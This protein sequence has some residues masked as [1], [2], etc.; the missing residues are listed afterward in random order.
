MTT[1]RSRPW[2]RWDD[3]G[4]TARIDAYWTSN[5][6]ES[7]HRRALAAFVS[8]HARGGP[9]LEVGSGTGLV[10]E[11]LV[12]EVLANDG[13]LGMDVSAQ[14]VDIARRRFPSGRF[15][16][17]DAYRM[18]FQDGAFD[19]AVAFEVFCHLPAL[20]A[21]LK[22]MFRVSRRKVL[23]TTWDA[24]PDAS[25]REVTDEG[26]IYWRY[27]PED[28][29]AAV[30]EVAPDSLAAGGERMYPSIMAWSVDVRPGSGER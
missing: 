18:P 22:E 14:M 30:R 28:V 3:P 15:M 11:R 21:P 12:P 26:F 6:V 23:F 5:P 20:Q 29:L 19:M 13:Y 25:R 16:R 7:S 8:R 17:A 1:A 27:S 24:G 4:V 10:Y 9:V 2:E